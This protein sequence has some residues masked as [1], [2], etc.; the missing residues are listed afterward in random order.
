MQVKE[1]GTARSTWTEAVVVVVAVV[2]A[3]VVVVVVVAAVAVALSA[4]STPVR[5]TVDQRQSPQRNPRRCGGGQ[6]ECR[7]GSQRESS[8][9][10][11]VR[12]ARMAR[13]TP[14]EHK[15]CGSFESD[16]ARSVLRC[17]CAP[18]ACVYDP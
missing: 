10:G 4:Q 5:V 17:L 13:M 18:D 9:S 16:V 6:C 3:A 1:K 11:C 8:G 2:A 15:Q 12:M 14:L 7:D